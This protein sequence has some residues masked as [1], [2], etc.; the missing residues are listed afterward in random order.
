MKSK[1]EAK[2]EVKNLVEKFES[3][4]KNEIDSMSEDQIKTWFIEPLFE[5]LGWSRYNMFKEERVLKGRADY[6]LR[7]GNQEKLVIEAKKVPVRLEEKEGRQAVSYAYHRKIKFSVLTNFKDFRVYHALANIKNIDKNLLKKEGVYFILESKEFVEKFDLLW[8]LSKES[9][10]KGEINKLLSSK[11]E[12]TNKPIDERIL[13]DLLQIRE[14]LSKELKSKK[15]GEI[16]DE[17]IDEIVQIMIDRLIFM[18]S[19]EDR[20]LEAEDFLLKIMQSIQHGETDKS[21][22]ALLKEQFSRFNLVYDSRLFEKGILEEYGFFS[23]ETLN[24]VIKILYYGIEHSQE[25]YMFDEIPG[26]LFGNIYEQ[27]LGTILAGTDKRV[28]LDSSSGKRKKMGIYY[29][30]SYI[31]DYIVKNTVREYIKDKTIDE[32][33]DVNIVDP[34]CGSGSFLIRAFKEVCDV[35]EEKLKNG[36]RSKKWNTFTDYKEKLNFA[37]KSTILKNCIYGVD[38]DEKAVEL[39]QLN[40]LLKCLEGE[41]RD[42]KNRKLPNLLSNIKNG[43]SLIDDSKVAGDKAFNW[44]AQFKDEFANGGFDI[45]IGNPPYVDYSNIKGIEWI[46]NNYASARVNDKI[47]KYNL[48]QLFIEK[49]IKLLK[50]NGL[51]GFINPNTYLSAD[52]AF[53]LRRII[54]KETII[55]KI[56]DV[57]KLPVFKDASTY[58]VITIFKKGEDKLNK[59]ETL[60]ITNENQFEDKFKTNQISQIDFENDNKLNFMINGNNN[61]KELFNKLEKNKPLSEFKEIF[62]WGSSI[63]GFATHKAINKEKD[64]KYAPIIQTRDI[65]RYA[66]YWDK[67]YIK[68]SIYSEKLKGLFKQKKLVI[69]RV[70]K[71]IQA[72]I[73]SEKYFVGKSS[74]LIPKDKNLFEIFLAIINSKLINFYYKSKFETTHMAGGYLRFDIPYLSKIPIRL[75]SPSQE[76]KIVDLVNLMLELQKKYHDSGCIGNEK[77]RL[78]QQIDNVDYEIDQEVYKLY[79]LTHEEIKIV[80]DSLR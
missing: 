37:Q 27:Y 14:L 31:T 71:N 49:S 17:S 61:S 69:A 2:E 74:I 25:R 1:E 54:L 22:W 58:P 44:H 10:E 52:N 72:T 34:A 68:K 18:R 55:K 41:S 36:E 46:N 15:G 77:E 43:N 3:Y 76:K 5:A 7:I 29:T 47:V 32:I 78:K 73:D 40:L 57:S 26:D 79:D 53:S 30:P 24:K 64:D 6:I 66:I 50:E 62:V 70:T 19:V 48:F 11:D 21:L 65:K 33:L 20:K 38:L 13:E 28:K 80:E 63:T 45:V 56:I 35:L 39:A 16:K 42:L 67:E 60:Q 23:N 8:L 9:F 4:S 12:K 51:F 75:P 59:L